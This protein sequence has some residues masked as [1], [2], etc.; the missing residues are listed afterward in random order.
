MHDSSAIDSEAEKSFNLLCVLVLSAAVNERGENC[1]ASF[2]PYGICGGVG[3]E[4]GGLFSC[5]FLSRAFIC[6]AIENMLHVCA[7]CVGKSLS[8]PKSSTQKIL[9][10]W[11]MSDK[12]V[13]RTEGTIR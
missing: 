8:N 3:V 5:L 10:R 13:N 1:Q 12:R 9:I 4:N 2:Y 6:L 7:G 11:R